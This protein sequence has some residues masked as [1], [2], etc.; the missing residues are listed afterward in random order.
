MPLQKQNSNT[1]PSCFKQN[2]PLISRQPLSK[3]EIKNEISTIKSNSK[4]EINLKKELKL[5][6]QIWMKL[7]KLPLIKYLEKKVSILYNY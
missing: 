1:M 7:S 5:C 2:K 4:S 3:N 6:S